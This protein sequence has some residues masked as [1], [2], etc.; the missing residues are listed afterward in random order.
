[1]RQ[2]QMYIP[3]QREAPGEAEAMSHKLLVRAGFIRQSSAG[4]YSYLPLGLRVLQRISAIIRQE[5]EQSGAQETLMP[6]MQPAELWEASGRYDAYGPELIRFRDRHQR[7]FALGPT[8]EEMVTALVMDDLHSYRQLP[9][10]LYQLQSKFRDERRPRFGLLRG[11]EFMMKDAYSFDADWEGLQRTYQTM[12]DTYE[13]IFIR[14]GLQVRAVEADAGSIGG[15]G[16]THEFMALADIGEDTIVACSSCHYAANLE[17]AESGAHVEHT[18]TEA[19]S[20]AQSTAKLS[21]KP[22]QSDQ[23][24]QANAGMEKFDTPDVKTI[25]Q[26]TEFTGVRPE[27]IMKTL[28]YKADGQLVAVLVR[29]DH[30]VNEIKVKHALHVET[31]ELADHETIE[32][33]LGAPAGFI[34][35]VGLT[36]P[37][38]MDWAA[39]ARQTVIVG[40]NEEGRHLRNVVPGRDFIA[41]QH[42]D[43]RNVTEEDVCPRCAGALTFHRG[44]EVGQVFKL[45]T[46]YS[47]KLG[48]NFTGADGKEQPMIMGCYGI[49]VSRLLA[50]AAE[51]NH[52]Q[53]GFVWP[54][55]IAP[56]QVHLIVVSAKDSEQRALAEEIYTQLTKSGLDVLLDDREERPGVK[57]KDAD[58]I[59]IPV[60]LTIGRQ[61]GERVVEFLERSILEKTI[62]PVGEAIRRIQQACG[63]TSL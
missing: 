51:Q 7:A 43:Y 53:A 50:A 41:S 2:S 25:Q 52:D 37:I 13:R 22:L 61:A 20:Q 56:F 15:E 9:V 35:P 24:N 38:L 30:E 59:G 46:K 28:V 16:G 21:A 27:Q 11:R 8:H 19:Q 12:Y 34:G 57:F 47:A 55:S 62:L 54:G 45:G 10:V 49:G 44:I 1:M 36:V 48:A 6:I 32:R 23:G 4:V 31:L 40:A 63:S 29:G 3:T 42:G 26:L 33:S 17:K 39:S 5:M 58:L 14:C 60:R 18:E